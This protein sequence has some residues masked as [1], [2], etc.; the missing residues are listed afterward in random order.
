MK[1]F[2]LVWRPRKYYFSGLKEESNKK[3]NIL[4]IV[5]SPLNH[6]ASQLKQKKKSQS[7]PDH[8]ILGD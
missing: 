5:G 7:G 6:F 3:T 2:G 1:W 8:F 4:I